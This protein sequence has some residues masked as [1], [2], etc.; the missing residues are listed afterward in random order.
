[1]A[2]EAETHP[3]IIP[4]AK[5]AARM[6]ISGFSG[7][8]TTPKVPRIPSYYDCQSRTPPVSA[9][10]NERWWHFSDLGRCPT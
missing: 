6:I 9:C 5:I 8:D 7:A 1:M 4:D 2:R 10:A 3:R